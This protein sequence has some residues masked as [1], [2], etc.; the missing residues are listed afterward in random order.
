[1]LVEAPSLRHCTVLAR[2][3]SADLTL[4]WKHMMQVADMYERL[5]CIK[6]DKRPIDIKNLNIRTEHKTDGSSIRVPRDIESLPRLGVYRQ[7]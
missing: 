3:A 4:K 5:S 7:I 6:M 2:L 1:M